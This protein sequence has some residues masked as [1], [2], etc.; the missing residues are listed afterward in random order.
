[1][2]TILIYDKKSFFYRFVSIRYNTLYTVEKSV[3]HKGTGGDINFFDVLL[4]VIYDENDLIELLNYT[5]YEG[6]MVL[7]SYN[8]DLFEQAKEKGYLRLNLSHAKVEIKKEL[9]NLFEIIKMV[10]IQ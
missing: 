7:C 1:M 2:N 3:L 4:F 8:E 9:D 5:D 10:F 6:T